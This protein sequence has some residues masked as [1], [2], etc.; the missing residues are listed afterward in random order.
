MRSIGFVS[1]KG[2]VAKTTTALNVA[3]ALG[4]GGCRVLVVDTDPQGNASHVLLRGEKPRRPTLHEVLTGDADAV[5]AIV[6]THFAG[7]DVLPADAGLADATVALAAEVGRERRL[8]EALDG[9][10]KTY[11]FVLVDT[12]PTRSILT[13]NVLNAVRELIVPFTPG[14]FGVLGLGQLQGDVAQV[15]RYLENK[16]LRIAGIVLTQAER[17]NVHQQLE[18]QL[19]GVFGPL[20]YATKI[21]RSIKIEEAH[22]RHESVLTY[23]PRSIGA[24]AYQAL[25]MEI[26]AHGQRQADRD[27]DPGGDP[28]AHHAA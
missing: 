10:H 7:V 3:A 26:T 21:P 18:D 6:P 15:R 5:Q 20:V 27:A 23:A 24:V 12:A 11:G 8:R 16:S 14:L 19:R 22:A 28:P 13:T 17:N 9:V 4:Q 25:A 1:E 2:G